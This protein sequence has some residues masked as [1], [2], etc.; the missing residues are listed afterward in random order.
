MDIR[1][2]SGAAELRD[3][4]DEHVVDSIGH[5]RHEGGFNVLLA[6]LAAWSMLMMSAPGHRSK[7]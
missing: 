4:Q 7:L 2:T 1:I 3:L 6:A 5:I